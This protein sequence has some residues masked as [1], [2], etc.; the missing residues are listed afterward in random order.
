MSMI[1]HPDGRRFPAF[2]LKG[3]VTRFAAGLA[4]LV[5]IGFCAQA[6]AHGYKRN[7]LE[8]IHP[9]TFEKPEP[10]GRDAIVGMT[11]RN[12]GK[13]VEHLVG[14]TSSI[15]ERVEIMVLR[16]D[17]V[18]AGTAKSPP[19]IEIRPGT[20]TELKASSVHVRLIGLKKALTAYDTL[21]VTLNFERAGRM[22][23][24]VMVEE[25]LEKK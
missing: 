1:R 9:Y 4:V 3:P 5:L 6:T 11:L 2:N 22:K 18:S 25:V 19:R 17:A 24:D 23:I 14:A 12:G 16:P 21:P 20:E 13:Q 10:G 15:A 8:V 7:T